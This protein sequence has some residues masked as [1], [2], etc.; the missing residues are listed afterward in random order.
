MDR[1]GTD[2][3][4][5]R[6]TIRGGIAGYE[7]YGYTGTE[8]NI[9]IPNY[10]FGQPVVSIAQDALPT[11]VISVSISSN[12]KYLPEFEDYYNLVSFDFNNAAVTTMTNYMFCD[13]T[14]LT[15]I[16]NYGNLTTIPNYAFYNTN[17]SDF[18]FTNVNY[19]GSYAFYQCSSLSFEERYENGKHGFIYIPNQATVINSSAFNSNVF[20]YFA[21]SDCSFSSNYLYKNVKVNDSGYYYIDYG[22]YVS[23]LNYTGESTR[24]T[25]PST[26]ASKTV[27]AIENYAFIGN[28]KIER[29]EIPDGVKKIGVATFAFCENLHSL[30][31]PKS[32]EE[33]GEFENYTN[34]FCVFFADANINYASGITSPTDLDVAKYM[35]GIS[36]SDISD[37]SSFV[38]YKNGEAY[39]IVTIKNIAGKVTVPAKYNDLPIT[40]INKYALY[41]NT[42]TTFV[43]ISQ[44]VAKISAYS[45]Y[46]SS[47][48][49]INV[50]TSVTIV[51]KYGFYSLSN[52]YVNFAGAT[53]PE[54]WD[55][56]WR[57]N[58]KGYRL[59]SVAKV[60][61]TGKY[62]YEV[63]SGLVYLVSYLA[64]ITTNTPIIIPETVDNLPVFGIRA[65][66]YTSTYS[67]SSSDRFIFV[68]SPKIVI[69]E[70]NAIS[71]NGYGYS[72][73]YMDM[74][75]SGDIPTTWNSYWF[76]S[77]YGYSYNNSRNQVY[78]KSS[79]ELVDG[80]PT[81]K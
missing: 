49:I 30:F 16:K 64:P 70:S 12:T 23:I 71:L 22:T 57:Y 73:L 62:Q 69:M 13:C 65:Y 48:Q 43:D 61:S 20:V 76:Y 44:G 51:N 72:T 11:S 66:C 4:L 17:I 58:I 31:I 2:G 8:K 9:V 46:Q 32:V 41:Y 74:D 80:V 63:V 7:V 56:N 14:A 24:I 15:E 26:I 75:S 37:D 18:D 77:S 39:E 54:D 67:N 34:L 35:L 36:P 45:F 21:G 78:Y 53:I 79:W 55:S 81:L 40:R 38:Y 50:P 10:I 29:V 19:I 33:C 28:P 47:V 25:I 6:T 59:S 68:I 42:V 27:S 52:C 3:L 5:F 1:V 60:D